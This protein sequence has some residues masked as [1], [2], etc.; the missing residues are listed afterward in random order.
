MSLVVPFEKIFFNTGAPD[1]SGDAACY[2][3]FACD[4]FLFS[5]WLAG[6]N[7]CNFIGNKRGT[8]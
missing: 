6:F 4:N 1:F 3:Q 8:N 5:R 7:Y 2:K